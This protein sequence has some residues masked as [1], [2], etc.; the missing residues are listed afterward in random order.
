M[1]RVS[2][3]V[4]VQMSECECCVC[5]ICVPCFRI[6]FERAYAECS[7]ACL[8][9]CGMLTCVLCVVFVC[10]C[11]CRAQMQVRWRKIRCSGHWLII[12]NRCPNERTFKDFE[13]DV[14]HANKNH[15]LLTNARGDEKLKEKQ[16]ILYQLIGHE[17][18]HTN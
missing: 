11:V 10:A 9:V 15:V 7:C 2:L 8:F 12:M 3:C 4:C 18:E 14:L 13:T 1:R 6:L 16:K 17:Q 5:S